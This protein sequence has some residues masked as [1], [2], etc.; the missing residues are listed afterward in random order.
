MAT[1]KQL[2]N[3]CKATGCL[4]F[5]DG[6]SLEIVAPDGHR[7]VDVMM[8]ATVVNYASGWGN[9]YMPK[10]EAYRYLIED[11]EGGIEPCDDPECE[12]CNDGMTVEEAYQNQMPDRIA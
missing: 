11:L 3:R 1:R 8:H 9:T 5:D 4:C 12:W 2:I 6:C 7:L 10:A